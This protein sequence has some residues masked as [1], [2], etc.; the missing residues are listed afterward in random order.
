MVFII[1]TL[2]LIGSG[3]IAERV[4]SFVSRREGN[5]LINGLAFSL[6]IFFTNMVGMHIFKD[7]ST[8]E[9]LQ[10]FLGNVVY[11]SKYMLLSI[12]VGIVLAIIL[13]LLRRLFFWRN[14]F[15]MPENKE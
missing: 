12:L 9:K 13:G 11:S 8:Y 3:F 7:L 5:G 4:F 1:F 10:K 14:P 6:L 15:R 2:I